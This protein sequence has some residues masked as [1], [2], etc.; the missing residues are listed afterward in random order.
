MCPSCGAVPGRGPNKLWTAV[1]VSSTAMTLMACYGVA[2]EDEGWLDA[3]DDAGWDEGE[4]GWSDDGESG[5]EETGTGTTDESDDT[6]TGDTGD[7]EGECDAS[8][9]ATVL[10]DPAPVNVSGALDPAESL[11]TGTCGGA[12][13]ERVFVWTAPASGLY[14]FTVDA[15]FDAVLYLRA[16]VAGPCGEELGCADSV[17]GQT[18]LVYMLAGEPVSVVVDSDDAEDAGGQFSLLVEA[19]S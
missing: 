13:P 15:D 5:W 3:T 12:G 11:Q 1:A 7:T 17:T 6:D 10:V 8:A 4:S 14:R 18:Q 16:A 9:P 19:G 2:F